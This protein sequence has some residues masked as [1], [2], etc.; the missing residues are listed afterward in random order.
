M[1]TKYAKQYAEAVKNNIFNAQF[2]RPSTLAL[3]DDLK[4]LDVLDLGCGSGE[5]AEWILNQSVNKLT[6]LDVSHEMIA[7]V[8]QRFPNQVHA[9]QADLANGLPK[10][11][12]QSADVIICPLVLHYLDDLTFFFKE[13]RRV[14][15]PNGY[16]VF[17]THHP[18]ADFE[19]SQSGNYFERE[20]VEEEWDTIGHPISVCFYRRSLAEICNAITSS[21]L[22]IAAISEGQV[23]EAAKKLSEETYNHLKNKPN[24]IFLRCRKICS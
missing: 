2:E 10:E 18:F 14:L 11:V 8:N 1:Y 12:D 21:G 15:K 16:L 13:I 23:Q 7:I 4:G 22:V 19:C 24:F 6:C 5:Y 9:Y 3:L 17:S 20:I